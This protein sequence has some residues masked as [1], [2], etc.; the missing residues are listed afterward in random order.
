[1]PLTLANLT[2]VAA[3]QAALNEY[4]R[5]GQSGFLRKHGF[6]RASGYVVQDPISGQ[7]ADSK[8]IAGVAVGIQHPE[9][10][11][12]RASEFSG[13]A[14]S[15]VRRLEELGFQ[16]KC[17]TG[18]AGG[19]WDREEVDLIVADYLAMLMLELAGQPYNKAAHR[20]QLLACMPKRTAAAIEFKH[21]NI[22]A[23]ML[24]LG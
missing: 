15:V 3:V 16:V 4:S 7:W 12:L 5:L 21:A 17:L 6:G 1:M 22:S 13:G 20:R 23:V 18:L 24:L 9:H 19:D 8:A 14:A 11:P 2:D 10:G